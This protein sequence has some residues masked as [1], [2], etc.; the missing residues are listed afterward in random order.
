MTELMWQQR[1][2]NSQAARKPASEQESNLSAVLSAVLLYLSFEKTRPWFCACLF[3]EN[4]FVFG[5]A[6]TNNKNMFLLH[7]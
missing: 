3:L 7:L 4:I 6:T 2:D 5:N 1:A